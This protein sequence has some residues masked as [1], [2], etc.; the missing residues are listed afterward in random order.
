MVAL[1]S[2]TLTGRSVLVVDDDDDTRDLFATILSHCGATVM[3]ASSARSAF[4]QFID[5]PVDIVVS[6]LS[7]PEEDG[8]WLATSLRNVMAERGRAVPM[9]AVTAHGRQY[10]I[11]RAL[12]AGFTAYLGKPIEPEA[13]CDAVLRLTQRR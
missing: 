6:D 1:E 4:Q 10:P 2:D 3:T 7:M 5:A 8:C 12:A 11:H 13:L 9:L